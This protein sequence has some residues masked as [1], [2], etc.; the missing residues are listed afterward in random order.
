[1]SG[2]LHGSIGLARA[3]GRRAAPGA[4][5]PATGAVS[6][7]PFPTAAHAGAFAYEE[8]RAEEDGYLPHMRV[9]RVE[10]RPDT[11]ANIA[12][13]RDWSSKYQLWY[14]GLGQGGGSAGE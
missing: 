1:M 10:H 4:R 3:D 9:A 6:H 11:S 2:G 7:G 5:S 8:E 13:A 14:N 12:I